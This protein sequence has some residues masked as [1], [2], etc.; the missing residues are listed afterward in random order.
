VLLGSGEQG[1]HQQG[2]QEESLVMSEKKRCCAR[3]SG[4]AHFSDKRATG[5]F[6]EAGKAA[7]Q[8]VAMLISG[9]P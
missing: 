4:F 7:A 3:Y 2:G 8:R 5:W 6:E 1:Q 9:V